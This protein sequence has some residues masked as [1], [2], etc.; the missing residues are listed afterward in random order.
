MVEGQNRT[1][2]NTGIAIKR[3]LVY[4]AHAHD[5]GQFRVKSKTFSPR[6]VTLVLYLSKYKQQQFLFLFIG[7]NYIFRVS[8]TDVVVCGRWPICKNN[9]RVFMDDVVVCC[10]V[11]L[12]CY[13]FLALMVTFLRVL[14]LC[15]YN[16]SSIQCTLLQ[17]TLTATIIIC[18]LANSWLRTCCIVLA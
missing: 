1:G 18:R 15:F 8:G 7:I 3:F 2:D 6:I 11:Y 13:L 9:S 10:V 4:F 5:L 17:S 12:Q 14:L 16:P